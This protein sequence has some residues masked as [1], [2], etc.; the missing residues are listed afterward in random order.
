VASDPVASAYV[1]LGARIGNLE[2]A[3]KKANSQVTAFASSSDRQVG[4]ASAGFGRLGI[5]MK[6]AAGAFI[7]T[8]AIQ[9]IKSVTMAASDLNESMSKT[10]VIFGR[11]AGAIEQ[12]SNRAATSMG[13]SK[14]AALDAASTFAVFGKSAGLSGKELTGFSTRLVGLSADLASFYNTSP[15]EAITAIGAALRG[16]SEPIRR[17]GV[18]LDD[19]TLKQQALAMGIIKTTKGSLTPQQRVLAAQ[20]Q[21]LKQTSDAQGDFQRTAGGAANQSRIFAAQVANAKAQI[22]VGLLPAMTSL[23]PVLNEIVK[24]AVPA[25]TQAASAFGSFASEVLRSE[26][27]RSLLS[28]IGTIAQAAFTTIG[29]VVRGVI[30]PLGIFAGVLSGATSAIA[31]FGPL[32]A[33][34]TGA[35]AALVTAM[36][37]NKVI[38]FVGGLRQLA[39]VQAAVSGVTAL[40]SATKALQTGFTGVTA[41]S[42][43]LAPGL[44]AAQAGL[45]K[46][47][48]AM[49]ALRTALTGGGNPWALA[50]AGVGLLVGGIAALSSGLFGGT[51][52]AQAYA[53]ALQGLDTAARNAAGAVGTLLG[54]VGNY[55]QSQM[56]TKQAVAEVAAAERQV[57]SLRQQGITSGSQYSAAIQRLTSA[58]AQLATS[59][60]NES[61]AAGQVKQS[62][63][64]L[65]TEYT[66]VTARMR[67]AS[68]A[69]MTRISGLRLAAQAGGQGSKAAKDYESAVDALNK[70]LSQDQGFKSLQQNARAAADQFDAM[71]RADLAK[72]L[73]DIANAKPGDILNNAAGKARDFSSVNL[74]KNVDPAITKFDNLLRKVETLDGKVASVRVNVTETKVTGKYVGGYVTGFASGGKVR[75][76]GGR[77]KVPAMLTAGE[78]VLNR[79]QQN[80]VNGGMS[81]DDA[82]RRTGAAFAKGRAA[83]GGS[84]KLTPAQERIKK[85]REERT[86][87]IGTAAGGLAQA[88]SSVALKQ[89][90]AKTQ[91]QLQGM[92]AST[93]TRMD[94]IGREYQ[95]GYVQINGAWTRITGSLENA[96]ATTASNLKS[97]ERSFKGAL[98]D[99]QGN[100]VATEV[101]FRKFDLMMRDAQKSLTKFYDEL[102]PAESRIR[103]LQ[104]AAQAQDLAGAVS[105]AQA[106]LREAQ[107]FGDP[108]AIASA[109]KAVDDAVRAQ[110]IADLQKTAEEERAQREADRQAAQDAFDTEWAGR[111]QNLQDQLDYKLEQERIAGE[112]SRMLLEAQMAQRQA[113]EE[114]ALANQQAIYDAQRENERA[115]LEGALA[116]MTGFFDNVRNLSLKK[117]KGTVARLNDLATAFLSSGKALG[118]NFADGLTDVL[119]RIGAAGRAI[120]QI[121]KDYLKT[122]SPT[123]KGPM[124]DLDTWF[125][126]LASGLAQG[127]DTR[128]LEGTIA[129]ATGA[130]QLALAGGS[131]EITINLNVSDQTMAGMSREQA[132]RVAREIQ[133]ALDRQVRATI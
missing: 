123:K 55:T 9:G 95:G 65:R 93:K 88:L 107:D 75:G 110:T 82:L 27:F 66:N 15:E 92:A 129:S 112:N 116:R 7:V 102:T 98:T 71:G 99:T 19:A 105:D 89:F 90:D 97:I 23:M 114:A 108:A 43:G 38:A 118:E 33:V 115:K 45:S 44:T 37:V 78:V 35:I 76:P 13:L 96:Q 67:E 62:I 117:T 83:K 49:T 104:D 109:K 61:Q 24:A 46:A 2:R 50:A 80:L 6:A 40:S 130:P 47:G 132:D 103:S 126:G 128:A 16:E 58:Q 69:E 121:L 73:R 12:F 17:Y 63:G 39:V 125:N 25:F 120:A 22:G 127:V 29:N 94:E 113:A 26:G 14:T 4:R 131:G 70:R 5:A 119:P 51:P 101:S 122:G 54:A 41:A 10:R 84:K 74:G 79:R 11:S 8:K 57:Q 68:S 64:T 100:V 81:I 72:P 34:A 18:L 60:G 52:P 77:D 87:R 30:G 53:Q 20:A 111:R 21:I 3:L 85:A 1:E 42:I 31:G 28:D 124:S 48:L 106:K 91:A 32:A 59:M 56:A 36:A 133:S 86:Q